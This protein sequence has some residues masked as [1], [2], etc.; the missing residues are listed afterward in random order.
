MSGNDDLIDALIEEGIVPTD[1]AMAKLDC[2][3][4]ELALILV[5]Y[6][7]Y[8]VTRKRLIGALLRRLQR[9]IRSRKQ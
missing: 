6:H 4:T 3:I 8:Q 1:E 2:D 7:Q 9:I 5:E